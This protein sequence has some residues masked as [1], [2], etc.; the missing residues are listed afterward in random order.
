MIERGAVRTWVV[1]AATGGSHAAAY[2]YADSGLQSDVTYT[3]WL[4]EL[5]TSGAVASEYA[6]GG[7]R[8]LALR[9]YLPMVAR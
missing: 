1:I 8:V 6:L 9:M 4:Q 2:T 3:Y 7:G 5:D